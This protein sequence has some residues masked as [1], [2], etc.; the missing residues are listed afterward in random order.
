MKLFLPEYFY[1]KIWDIPLD[2][3]KENNFLC[4]LLDIDNTLTMHDDP[5]PHDNA[6]KWLNE[7]KNKGIKAIVISNNIEPR[8]K[9]FCDN[10]DV[11]YVCHAQKPL[12]RGVNQAVAL[13]G[14]KKENMLLVGDQIFTDVLC[15]KLSGVKTVLVTPFENEPM[16]FFKVKRWFEKIILRGRR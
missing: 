1:D 2:F 16:P 14:I 11:Q 8:V 13:T 12:S 9:P 6:V 3:L 4:L 5:Y 7:S 15:G 10:L